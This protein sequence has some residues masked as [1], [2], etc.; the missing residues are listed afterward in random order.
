MDKRLM[1]ET[2]NQVVILMATYKGADY[3]FQQLNSITKQSYSNIKIIIRDDG[4]EDNTLGEIKRFQGLEPEVE[5]ELHRN[6]SDA[7]GHV[8]NFSGL[9][10]IALE[11]SNDYFC[12]SDQDDIWDRDKVAIM[13]TRVSELEAVY[14]KDVPIL[15]HSDL[16]VV[17]ETGQL[18][19]ESFV[20]YQ[21][22][23]PPKEHDFPKFYYQN[24]VTGCTTL[25]NRA[26]LEKAC[27]LPKEVVV[28][29][30]WFAQCAKL[31]GLIEFV[32][33]P[34]V[35]YRQHNNNAIGAKEKFGSRLV[36]WVSK[37][38]ALFEFPFHLS[39]S[40]EQAKQL[41]LLEQKYENSSNSVAVE[42][43]EFANLKGASSLKRVSFARIAISNNSNLVER[44]YLQIVFFLIRWI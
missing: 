4:S 40:I 3:I 28:H 1:E 36:D 39:K 29:D 18:I 32:D 20:D 31:F 5:I 16:R 43:S 10:K 25:F 30:W 9:S 6:E 21:G 22:L 12:F 37:Y 35:D 8:Q 23:P 24:V 17:D 19:N 33:I 2:E 38:K 34:L 7:K 27:P 42:L 11:T 13:K 26:L 15:I 14:G 44:L 41:S